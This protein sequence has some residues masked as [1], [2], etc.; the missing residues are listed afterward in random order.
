MR[1]EEEKFSPVKEGG[2]R[3][4]GSKKGGTADRY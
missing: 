4:N 3:E 2:N 1:L